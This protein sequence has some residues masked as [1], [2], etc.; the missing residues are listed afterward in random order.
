MFSY[1]AKFAPPEQLCSLEED[2]RAG[3]LGCVDCKKLC[4]A[5]ISRELAPLI[6]RRRYYETNL[7]LVKDILF[8]GEVKARLIA[9][10]TMQEVRTAMRLGDTTASTH[11]G[12]AKC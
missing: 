9:N 8:E 6:E 12:Q 5:N 4:A 3:T 10:H 2:C 11:H 7:E 1:H